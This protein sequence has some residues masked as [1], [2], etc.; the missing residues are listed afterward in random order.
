MLESRY[1]RIKRDWTVFGFK[2]F[3]FSN[4]GH[5]FEAWQLDMPKWWHQKQA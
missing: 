5:I 1:S 2:P 4:S 3:L